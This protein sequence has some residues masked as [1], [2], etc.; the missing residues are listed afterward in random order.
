MRT[1]RTTGTTSWKWM[2]YRLLVVCALGLFLAIGIAGA[3]TALAAPAHPDGDQEAVRGAAAATAQ[4]VTKQD[5]APR[6]DGFSP[7]VPLVFAGIVILAAC[8][9]WVPYPRYV[10][11]RVERRW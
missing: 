8:G 1:R 3:S 10:Y 6:S 9:P 7:V 5:P 2:A 4:P 11:Y